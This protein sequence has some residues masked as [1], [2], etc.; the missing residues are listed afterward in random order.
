SKFHLLI[1]EKI[2]WT[3]HLD[4]F[5]MHNILSL[6]KVLYLSYKGL[7][8]VVSV[9]HSLMQRHVLEENE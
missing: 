7:D 2:E 8:S 9:V 4:R 5:S 6:N 3:K 1:G